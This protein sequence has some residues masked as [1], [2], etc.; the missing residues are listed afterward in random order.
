MNPEN[1]AL[2]TAETAGQLVCSWG[3]APRRLSARNAERICGLAR[4][5]RKPPWAAHLG[6]QDACVKDIGVG[7]L[8]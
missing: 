2:K 1:G 4:L 7:P 5:W 8:S 6:E 3:F